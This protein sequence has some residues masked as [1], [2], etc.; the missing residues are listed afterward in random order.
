[1]AQS[2]APRLG[3]YGGTFDPVHLGHLLV[4]H[5][6]RE[7]MHLDEVIFVPAGISPFKPDRQPAPAALRLR[8][9]RL[10]LAGLSWCRVSELDVRR[11][12]PSYSVD[13][14]RALASER[15][16]AT[17]LFI[18]GGDHLGSLGEWR[19][20]AALARL[21]EFIVIPRPGG[22]EAEVP[23]GFTAHGLAG[24]PLEVSASDLRGRIRAGRAFEHLV[25]APVAEVIRNNRLY[26]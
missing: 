23:P 12:G 15:P 20:S 10:A 21:V 3:I 22:A 2:E 8:M 14:V 19:E 7:E 24:W 26:L 1:M 18:I 5:A 25:A 6:A 17:L 13:T 11:E 16:E 9:L 4:A